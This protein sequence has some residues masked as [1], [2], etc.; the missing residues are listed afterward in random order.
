MLQKTWH[1]RTLSEMNELYQLIAQ[2][3]SLDLQKNCWGNITAFLSKKWWSARI[4]LCYKLKMLSILYIYHTYVYGWTCFEA[5]LHRNATPKKSLLESNKRIMGSMH[6]HG[7]WCKWWTT[8]HQDYQHWF[9]SSPKQ[10]KRTS[11]NFNSSKY[12]KSRSR[13]MVFSSQWWITST[14]LKPFYFC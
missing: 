4:C 14:G 6:H 9:A 5:V 2:Y 7:F 8:V 10:A 11:L 12:G 1:K 13:L 3:F